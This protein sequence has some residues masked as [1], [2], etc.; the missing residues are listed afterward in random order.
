LFISQQ[1]RS[2][3][4]TRRSGG[5]PMIPAGKAIIKMSEDIAKLG[6]FCDTYNVMLWM[7]THMALQN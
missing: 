7:S 6:G 1:V 5:V 4:T 3:G 2:D